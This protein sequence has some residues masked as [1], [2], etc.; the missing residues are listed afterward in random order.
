MITKTKK[1]TNPQCVRKLLSQV[2]ICVLNAGPI[3]ANALKAENQKLKKKVLR[4]DSMIVF[5]PHIL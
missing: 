4:P 2:H 1:L 3:G 5:I